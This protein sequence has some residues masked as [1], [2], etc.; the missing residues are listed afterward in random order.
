LGFLQ[1]HGKG[2]EYEFEV[3]KFFLWVDDNLFVKK[4]DTQVSMKDITQRLVKLGFATSN[5]FSD[6]K[7]K[8]KCI[9]FIWNGKTKMVF[10]PKKKLK[11]RKKGS[12][13][14]LFRVKSRI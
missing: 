6:F 7:D 8:Q 2:M 3:V 14:S 12:S 4:T 5:K 9:G 1:T 10:L 13:Q 11:E